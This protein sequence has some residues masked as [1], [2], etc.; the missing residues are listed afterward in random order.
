M[1]GDVVRVLIVAGRWLAAVLGLSVLCI[2]LA[3]GFFNPNARRDDIEAWVTEQTGRSFTLDGELGWQLWPHPAVTL[4]HIRLGLRPA[5]KKQ[6]MPSAVCQ[7]QQASV[8][9]VCG[10]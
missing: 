3:L 4:P 8:L 1:A 2:V 9:S 10:R 6:A 7:W 5:P